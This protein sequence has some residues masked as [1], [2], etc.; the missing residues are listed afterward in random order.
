MCH[1]LS[2]GDR[3]VRS[4]PPAKAWSAGFGI[5]CCRVTLPRERPHDLASRRCFPDV[6]L[7][8]TRLKRS[9][10]CRFARCI[11]NTSADCNSIRHN[12]ASRADGQSAFGHDAGRESDQRHETEER[13]DQELLHC[14]FRSAGRRLFG[15]RPG[16]R[17]RRLLDRSPC[18]AGSLLCA[19]RGAHRLRGA[20]RRRARS[21]ARR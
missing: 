15:C 11:V 20:H 16:P 13:D 5:K 12:I 9:R 7:R 21:C 8:T 19:G 6:G 14:N 18:P 17:R 2:R 3:H 4:E 10:D 1:R